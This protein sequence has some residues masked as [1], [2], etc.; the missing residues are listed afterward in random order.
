MDAQPYPNHQQK[1]TEDR[2]RIK[3]EEQFRAACREAG[4]PDDWYS[5]TGLKSRDTVLSDNAAERTRPV[6]I[7]EDVVLYGKIGKTLV[8][9]PMQRWDVAYE[10]LLKYKEDH[11]TFVGAETPFRIDSVKWQ[12]DAEISGKSSFPY[13]TLRSVDFSRKPNPALLADGWKYDGYDHYMDYS[14]YHKDVDIGTLKAEIVF[15]FTKR[16]DER[17][18]RAFGFQ[19]PF[20]RGTYRCPVP[21]DLKE[22]AARAVHMYGGLP[23]LLKS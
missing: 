15:E 11:D 4:I 1:E 19:E 7:G 8:S 22:V 21:P 16:T 23:D 6:I 18:A 9:I 12:T 20:L 3:S 13:V 2:C 5:L 17:D 14:N 10:E